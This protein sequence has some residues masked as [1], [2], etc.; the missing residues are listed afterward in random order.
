M[1]RETISLIA[2][3]WMTATA[4][5]H[6]NAIMGTWHIA[7]WDSRGKPFLSEFT[8][9]TNSAFTSKFHEPQHIL[10]WVP[11]PS[12]TYT[13]SNDTLRLAWP[14]I[15]KVAELHWSPTDDAFTWQTEIVTGPKTNPITKAVTY[16]YRREKKAPNKASDATSETAPGAASSSHQR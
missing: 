14:K 7:A 10:G 5:A 15:T 6:T 13:V 12:G 11:A 3:L 2:V 4:I 1:R 16:R 9:G 8:L